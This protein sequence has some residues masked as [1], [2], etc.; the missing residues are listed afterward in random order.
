M[1]G[2][3]FFVYADQEYTGSLALSPMHCL[4]GR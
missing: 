4:T 1:P 2:N 3:G